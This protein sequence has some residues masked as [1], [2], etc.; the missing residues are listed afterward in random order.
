MFIARKVTHAKWEPKPGM[1]KGEIPADAVTSDLRTHDNALSFWQ[2]G[3]GTDRELKDVVLAIAAG[4][5]NIDKVELVWVDDN[6]LCAEGQSMINTEG[7]TPVSDLV[8][9]QLIYAVLIIYALAK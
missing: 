3:S 8:N 4:R 1:H 6:D 7:Q 9:L 2:C 5:H